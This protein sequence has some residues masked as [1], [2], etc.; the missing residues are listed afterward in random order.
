MNF[1]YSDYIT[2]KQI[3]NELITI[4]DRKV[5]INIIRDKN[6]QE[7]LS[8]RHIKLNS[9]G[10]NMYKLYYIKNSIIEI[11]KYDTY[12]NSEFFEFN[13]NKNI[14]TELPDKFDFV[15]EESNTHIIIHSYY[16]HWSIS[17][18]R[19]GE[20]AVRLSDAY[21]KRADRIRFKC[22]GKYANASED[23]KRT[24]EIELM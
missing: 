8:N 6:L 10:Y 1:N 7:Y 12:P 3:D 11:D 15:N 18:C 20:C 21:S 14:L 5:L 13:E 17:E 22:S 4:V 24:V 19:I 16:I 23:F 2:F 9:W